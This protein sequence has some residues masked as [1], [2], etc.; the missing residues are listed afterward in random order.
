VARAELFAVLGPNG[1]GKSTLFRIL[2]TLVEV[3]EG[4]VS[5]LGLDVAAHANAIRRKIGVG[6]QAPSLDRK[7]TVRENLRHQ[8]HLY[9][10]SGPA[11]RRREDELLDRFGVADRAGD[12]VETLSGGLRRRVELAKALLHR[13]QL[14]L[15]DEP[16]TGLDPAARRDFVN[17]LLQLR[18]EF[19]LT[20]VLTTH[21]LDE[22]EQADRLAILDRGTIVAL[23][24]AA[25][26]RSELG[27][28]VISIGTPDPAALAGAIRDRL[29]LAPTV[30]AGAVRLRHSRARDCLVTLLEAFPDSIASITLARPTLEDVFVARTGRSFWES[31]GGDA[32]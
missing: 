4:R 18:R 23:G 15:F 11:L 19:G 12:L 1:S 6:F 21:L 28:D 25:E 3:Q 31:R 26:L 22:A 10:L 30:A 17:Y 27:G 32:A 29:G 2:C 9:G 14:L 13:P 24:A 20:V 5:V 16:S 8:G 7:L